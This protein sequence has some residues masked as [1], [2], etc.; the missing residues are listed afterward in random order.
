MR[1]VQRASILAAA[2]LVAV[3]LSAVHA[4]SRSEDEAAI[5]QLYVN[6][7][8]AW[9]AADAHGL[10]QLWADDAD[11]M[12]PDG[13]IIRGR[14]A[15]QQLFTDRFA[16]DLKGTRSQ[17]TIESVRFVTPDVAVVDASYEVT[18][19]HPSDGTDLPAI[20]GRYVDIWLKH[21]G[22]WRIAADRPMAAK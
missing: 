4:A 14:A 7:D 21:A 1:A 3:S 11:H 19:M 17:Q 22:K 5:R 9:N 13:R 20:H 8:A 18:G 6:Y 15:V 10:A 12:E 2:A 16:A